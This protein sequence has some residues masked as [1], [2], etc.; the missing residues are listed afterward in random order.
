[1]F[2]T[3][4]PVKKLC[5]LTYLNIIR[6]FCFWDQNWVVAQI[7]C[8]FYLRLKLPNDLFVFKL[9]GHFE[10]FFLIVLSIKPRL[11]SKLI[12]N[13]STAVSEF[14]SKNIIICISVLGDHFWWARHRSHRILCRNFGSSARTDQRLLQWSIRRKVRP[15]SN[16]RRPGE[17]FCF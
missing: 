17:I 11:E 12:T 3:L 14:N 10:R 5:N 15:E 4:C 7:Q 16:P 13:L 2:Q 9:F 1:M 8:L 6:S